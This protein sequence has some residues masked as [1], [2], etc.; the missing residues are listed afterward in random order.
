MQGVS[1]LVR[2]SSSLLVDTRFAAYLHATPSHSVQRLCPY[3]CQFFRGIWREVPRF[4]IS[5]KRGRW[6][7]VKCCRIQIPKGESLYPH[8]DID[9]AEEPVQRNTATPSTTAGVER[10]R[11]KENPL[12]EREGSKPCLGGIERTEAELGYS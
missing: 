11:L 2:I 6:S 5:I 7:S 4:D 9:L 1:Y 3:F 8:F 12:L 10:I